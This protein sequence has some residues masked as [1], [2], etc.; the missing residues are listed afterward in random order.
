MLECVAPG[1]GVWVW[2]GVG[3]GVGWVGLGGC[4]GG[5]GGCGRVWEWV[6]HV[7]TP[8]VAQLVERWTRNP[9]AAQW[10]LT[11]CHEHTLPC[12]ALPCVAVLQYNHVY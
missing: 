5:C 4:G 10:L 9:E 3:V 1:K 2:E 12:L 8:S 7:C 6:G 11:A